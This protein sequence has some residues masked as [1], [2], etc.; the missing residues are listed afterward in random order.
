M[1][2]QTVVGVNAFET[3]SDETEDPI[4]EIRTIDNSTGISEASDES[5]GN[6]TTD[7]TMLISELY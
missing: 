3:N 6:E 1:M 4:S 5:A 2:F 7:V